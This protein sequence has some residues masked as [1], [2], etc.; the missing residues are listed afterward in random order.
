M[1]NNGRINIKCPDTSALFNL[2]D[3]IPAH[4]CSTFRNYNRL[5]L[6]REFIYLP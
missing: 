5:L 1:N 3:K 6:V 4:Q 2:Y